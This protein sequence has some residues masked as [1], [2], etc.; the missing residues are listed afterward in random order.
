VEIHLD[1]YVEEFLRDLPVLRE[2]GVDFLHSGGDMAS[3]AGPMYSPQVFHDVL[4]PRLKRIVD[5][6]HQAGLFYVFRTD[7]VLW[8]VADDLFVASGADGYGEIDVAAGMDLLEVRARY[9]QLV[10]F[11][12]VECGE[13]LTNGSPEE[14]YAEAR[15]VVE[16][17]KPGGRHVL[18][19]SNS[20][21]CSVPPENYRA[22]LRAAREFGT[23]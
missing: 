23:Y 18:G 17:L 20:V 4:L 6:A 10:L 5:A 16:G 22:M 15:R 14:V 8:P 1:M 11:G 12:G 2:I 7:G 9:P 19:S 3:N 13:L 21:N